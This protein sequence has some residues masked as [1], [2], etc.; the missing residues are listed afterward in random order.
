MKRPV[1]ALLAT[2]GLVGAV[3]GTQAMAQ[4]TV[5]SHVAAA[6]AAAGSE[7]AVLFDGL[8]RPAPGP[9]P[10]ASGPRP[11]PERSTWHYEPVKVF[12][13]LYYV[14]EKE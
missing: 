10:Q 13:N 11:V 5:E 4:N 2:A 8:C 12:D 1:F 7:H 3:F 9:T 14:G 6:K